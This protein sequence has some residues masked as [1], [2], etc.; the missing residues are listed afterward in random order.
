MSIMIFGFNAQGGDPI[1]SLIC[2]RELNHPTLS[3][4]AFKVSMYEIQASIWLL[5]RLTLWCL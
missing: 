2:A 4:G 5:T 3:G 1:S